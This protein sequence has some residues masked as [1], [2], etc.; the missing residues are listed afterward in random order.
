MSPRT[1]AEQVGLAITQLPESFTPHKQLKKV[2][3]ARRA[4]IE[5]GEGVDWGMA[6]ALAFGTL[7]AEG[8]HVRL[9]GQVRARPFS[10]PLSLSRA[11]PSSSAAARSPACAL[12]RHPAR[13]C[14]RRRLRLRPRLTPSAHRPP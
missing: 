1:H 6:E 13:S 8:N 3:E 14:R 11:R 5:T 10:L 12:H 2:Y 7:L 4:M 9:S